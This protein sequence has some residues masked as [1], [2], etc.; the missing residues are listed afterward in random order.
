LAKSLRR[1]DGLVEKFTALLGEE[2]SV[3]RA[4]M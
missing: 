4:A 3:E 1:A 2:L